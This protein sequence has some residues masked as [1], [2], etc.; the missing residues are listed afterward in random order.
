MRCSN[1]GGVCRES[2]NGPS[3]R[4]AAGGP[5]CPELSCLQALSQLLRCGAHQPSSSPGARHPPHPAPW[6][7]QRASSS[8]VPP[9]RP[10]EPR[11]RGRSAADTV[12]LTPV[13]TCQLSALL[14]SGSPGPLGSLLLGG[15]APFPAAALVSTSQRPGAHPPHVAPPSVTPQRPALPH[16][17]R[18]TPGSASPAQTS[19]RSAPLANNLFP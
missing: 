12:R 14:G 15:P 8:P 5:L 3:P 9:P 17:V 13:V 19:L 1:E 16:G 10:L 11:P 2:G 6:S 18:D 7:E 4:A